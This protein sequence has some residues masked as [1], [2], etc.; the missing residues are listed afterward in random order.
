MTGE[1]GAMK[2][3]LI[4]SAAFALAFAGAAS[5][6]DAGTS[7]PA[8]D[9]DGFGGFNLMIPGDDLEAS[10]DGWNL[11]VSEDVTE[12]GFYIPD[13]VVT[14]RLGDVAAIPTGETTIPNISTDLPS[15]SE[16]ADDLIR[17]E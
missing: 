14:D 9:D 13:G 11:G 17:I 7:Q 3:S 5:A 4:V 15:L 12:D 2:T 1:Y 8:N 10:D 16:P 6:Q